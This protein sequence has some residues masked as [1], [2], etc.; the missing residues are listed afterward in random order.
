MCVIRLYFEPFLR[1]PRNTEDEVNALK[2]AIGM[3]EVH[4]HHHGHCA[5][6]KALLHWPRQSPQHQLLAMDS[7]LATAL[8]S[9]CMQKLAGIAWHELQARVLLLWRA[10]VADPSVAAD[11]RYSRCAPLVVFHIRLASPFLQPHPCMPGLHHTNTEAFAQQQNVPGLMPSCSKPRKCLCLPH[12]LL[13]ATQ[14]LGAIITTAPSE[15]QQLG[16]PSC[17]TYTT[18]AQRSGNLQCQSARPK[19]FA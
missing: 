2:A 14:W 6:Q 11:L 17:N 16:K 9:I 3:G 15:Q 10:A 1:N 13:C 8:A 5:S 19:G 18:S 4:H 7:N 12:D